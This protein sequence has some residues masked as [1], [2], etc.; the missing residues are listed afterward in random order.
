MN[1][2][3]PASIA[4]YFAAKNRR[5]I[6][7]M[8][9]PFAAAALVRDEGGEHRGHAAIRSW[10][11]ATTRKYHV[12]VEPQEVEERDGRTVVVG[13]VSGN[14]PGSPVRLRY[15]FI[16]SPDGISRLEIA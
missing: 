5:D 3:I 12:T 7:A 14:F 16:L 13:L 10:M 15:G 9:T 8:L 1:G 11:E 6:D 2:Q 4:A